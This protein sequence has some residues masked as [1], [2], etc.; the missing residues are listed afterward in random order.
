M[1]GTPMPA[2]DPTTYAAA[3][4][5]GLLSDIIGA[6]VS[7]NQTE[8]AMRE[9]KRQYEQGRAENIRQ[10][11][12]AEKVTKQ[13]L[14][15]AKEELGLQKQRFGEEKRQTNFAITRSMIKRVEDML[16]TNTALKDRVLQT[17][18]IAG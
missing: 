14:G 11:R 4:G 7:Y 6:I 17:W 12:F 5:L 10:N 16:N 18:A 1:N 15:L 3:T 9:Q 13:K 2:V 8:R